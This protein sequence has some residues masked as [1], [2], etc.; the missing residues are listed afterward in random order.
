MTAKK[1]SLLEGKG[2]GIMQEGGKGKLWEKKYCTLSALLKQGRRIVV[3]MV[4]SAG[5]DQKKRKRETFQ[6]FFFGLSSSSAA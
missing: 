6:T 4:P 5:G 1:K 3:L 2:R